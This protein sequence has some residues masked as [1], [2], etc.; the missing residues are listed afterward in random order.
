MLRIFFNLGRYLGYLFWQILGLYCVSKQYNPRGD[1]V[2]FQCICG[3]NREV[4][5]LYRWTRLF[6][7]SFC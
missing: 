2:Q 1:S 6:F 3:T 5:L 4:Q 7:Y